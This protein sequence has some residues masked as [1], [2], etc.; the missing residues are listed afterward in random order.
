MTSS[1]SAI[2]RDMRERAARL[3]GGIVSW[4]LLDL[5]RWAIGVGE[6]KDEFRQRWIRDNQAA[7]TAA[8]QG[9]GLPADLLA[10]IAFKE[11]GNKPKFLDDV[12][13]WLRRILPELMR[14]GPLRGGP[15]R[16][17]FGP[18]AIQVRRAAVT[19]GY[20][21]AHLSVRQRKE[22][23]AALKDPRQSIF[24]A[25][26]HL[27]ELKQSTDFAHTEPDHMTVE[28][29]RELAAR[30]NGGPYWQRWKAQRYADDFP[31]ILPIAREALR[32]RRT[33]LP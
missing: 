31:G 8:A 9:H 22:I 23:I 7:I 21:P 13:D 12:A 26:R 4:S 5:A 11:V 29:R 27:A 14:P 28:Q 20:E 30:Y 15:D 6:G 10:G 2:L 18:M 1:V 33:D 3:P 17:S 32:A 19:L 24:V 25:A 16:T